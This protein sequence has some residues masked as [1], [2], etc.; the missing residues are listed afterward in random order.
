ML[1]WRNIARAFDSSG[2][3]SI[4]STNVPHTGSYSL[5]YKKGLM[6]TATSGSVA[7]D[8]GDVPIGVEKVEIGFSTNM[9]ANGHIKRLTYW[10]TRQSDSTLQVITQ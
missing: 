9:Y 10:P 5:A 8:V 2:T 3:V 7:T 1:I 4:S 6:A